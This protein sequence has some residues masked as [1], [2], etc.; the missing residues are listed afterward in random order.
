MAREPKVDDDEFDAEDFVTSR[1]QHPH[2]NV[3][4]VASAAEV[5]NQLVRWVNH[6]LINDSDGTLPYARSIDQLL[7]SLAEMSSG[8]NQTLGYLGKRL[9]R[10]AGDPMLYDHDDRA[11]QKLATE[12]ALNGVLKLEDASRVAA[13]LASL[14]TTT[15]PGQPGARAYTGKLAHFYDE[16]EM[17]RN[18][19]QP[20]RLVQNKEN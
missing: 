4:A 14:L 18:R 19:P 17:R 11:D 16:E 3:E 9:E 2:Y 20:L 1:W 12:T 5:A 7:G 6:A 8:L 13:R 10:L 15:V